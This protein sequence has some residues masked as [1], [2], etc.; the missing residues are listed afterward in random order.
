MAIPGAISFDL[1]EDDAD[2]ATNDRPYEFEP[3]SIEFGTA[4]VAKDARGIMHA[5]LETLKG[6]TAKWETK[7]PEPKAHPYTV[8]FAWDA[9]DASFSINGK[10]VERKAISLD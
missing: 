9:N 7:L 10:L 2:W 3:V 8:A 1:I 6:K 5:T 4:T